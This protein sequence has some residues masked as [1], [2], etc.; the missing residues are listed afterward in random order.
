MKIG[1]DQPLYVLPFDHR[2]T[3]VTK[4]FGGKRPLTPG[5]KQDRSAAFCPARPSSNCR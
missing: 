2:D 5:P 3:F 4:M 1:Y